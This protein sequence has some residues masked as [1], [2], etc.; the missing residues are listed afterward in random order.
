MHKRVFTTALALLSAA[1]LFAGCGSGPK[2]PDNTPGNPSGEDPT[3]HVHDGTTYLSHGGTCSCGET[4]PAGDHTWNADNVC[5]VCGYELPVTEGLVYT[6]VEGG[7]KVGYDWE[8][9]TLTAAEELVIPAYHDGKAVVAVAGYY[10]DDGE[11]F[12]GET[13]FYSAGFKVVAVPNTVKN[14]PERAFYYCQNLQKAYIGGA[15]GGEMIFYGCSDL[16]KAVLPANITIIPADT[17]SD[18]AKLYDFEIPASVTEIGATAF[19]GAGIMRLTLPGTLESVGRNA[20]RHCHQLV[21]VYNQS[22]LTQEELGLTAVEDFHTAA[23]SA[24]TLTQ[25]GDYFFWTYNG[26]TFLLGYYGYETQIVL[27]ADFNGAGYAIHKSAFSGLDLVSVETGD[28]VT[29]IAEYA[30]ESCDDLLRVELGK[31]VET[32]GDGAFSHCDKLIEVG[33]LSTAL[34]ITEGDSEN[35]QIAKNAIHVYTDKSEKGTISESGEYAF[36]SYGENRLLVNYYGS[37]TA[38]TLPASCNGNKYTILQNLFEG[39]RT[40]TSVN[41]GDGV[42]EIGEKAF[43]NCSKLAS[44]VFGNSLE[45]IGAGA[46][47][48]TPLLT[49]VSFP[50]SLKYIGKDAFWSTSGGLTSA[51]FAVKE[52][53]TW[54]MSD[55]TQIAA[56][57]LDSL[58]DPAV[59]ADY[60]ASRGDYEEAHKI[61]KHE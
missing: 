26:A 4:F 29:E 15:L 24:G 7:V 10:Q 31:N 35:G 57:E 28:G 17:F 2:T 16:T 42:K 27:P 30:F 44:V 49:T 39:S 18:C 36:F 54:W 51:T 21:E 19:D 32:I 1:C 53:W 25:K 11:T 56:P 46:F 38:L 23:A 52:G 20:F 48:K 33:D 13:T 37:S 40:I 14:I 34:T 43:C 45:K 59:N 12:N 41:F 61:M 3:V 60:L 6:E 47:Q 22:S 50:A 55:S 58:D 8:N 5:T 9:A